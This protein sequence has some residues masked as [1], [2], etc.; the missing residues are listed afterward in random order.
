MAA[1]SLG[2]WYVERAYLFDLRHSQVADVHELLAGL[3]DRLYGGLV[4]GQLGLQPLVLLLE[5]LDAGEVAAIVVRADQQLL[6]LDPR[7]L[8]GDVPEELVQR[9]GL[10]EARLPVGG[11]VLDSLVALVDRLPLL[12]DAR[13][14][15]LA[16]FD[17]RVGLVIHV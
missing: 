3:L 1:G 2:F 13:R 14:V 9:V 11:Q 4:G 12:V 10:V 17:Q 6:L 7:L 5:V 8:V 16:A 15:E